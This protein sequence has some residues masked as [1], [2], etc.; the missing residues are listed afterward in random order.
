[1]TYEEIKLQATQHKGLKFTSKGFRYAF[2][3]PQTGSTK[4]L[5]QLI[6]DG[7]VERIGS[8]QYQVK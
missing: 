5:N 7:I 4:L 1:M 8:G 3:T 6:T 2:N